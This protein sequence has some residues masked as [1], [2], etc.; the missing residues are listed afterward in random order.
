MK[1]YDI[2]VAGYTCV[3]LIPDF[4]KTECV[5]SLSD[6]FRPGK[7]I[8]IDGINIVLGGVV[9]NTGLAMKKFNKK[10]FLNGLVGDDFMGKIIKEGFKKYNC[11]EGIKTTKKEGTAFSIVLAPPGVDRIFLESPGCNQIFDTR[12]INFKAISQSKVFHFGYP[13]LLKQFY[14]NDGSQLVEM[15]SEIQKMGVVTS[16]DFSLP[17][18][19]SESGKINW[20]EVMKRILPY[21]DIFVPSLEEALQIMMPLKYAEIQAAFENTEKVY[22]I[23]TPLIREVGRMIMNSGV[24]ILLIKAGERGA[25]LLTGDVTPINE[26]MDINLPARNWNFRELWCE[27]YHADKLK[28]INTNGAGDTAV[29]AFL[30]AIIDG[31]TAES[32]LKYAAIAGRN[33]LYCQNIHNDLCDWLEMTKGIINET[34]E[35]V[36]FNEL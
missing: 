20:P 8:E 11:S 23:P 10:V 28:I 31:Y 7:L 6:L 15:F 1:K 16:L 24:K 29:A 27:A 33:T 5:A 13:P 17:D 36:H 14:M 12:F 34:N 21:T 32:S 9:A 2:T 26:K 25:Y 35:M 3:D 18:P 19:E 30:S 22:Q 4:K